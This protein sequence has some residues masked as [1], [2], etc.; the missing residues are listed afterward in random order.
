MPKLTQIQNAFSAG[1]ISPRLYGRTDIPKYAQAAKTMR[2]AYPLVHGGAR[3][4][5]GLRKNGSDIAFGGAE[6][7][8]VPFAVNSSE[9]YFVFV[10]GY[11]SGSASAVAVHDMRA[12]LSSLRF[13]KTGPWPTSE[14]ENVRWARFEDSIYFVHPSYPPYRL[15]RLSSD[16]SSANAFRFETVPFTHQPAE[17]IGEWPNASITL[18][19]TSGA[20]VNVTA[21]AA[22]FQTSDVGRYIESAAGRGLITT[23]TSTTQVTINTGTTTFEGLA[24]AA[25]LWR[26]SDS[27]QTTCTPSTT[28]PIGQTITLTLGAAGWK[29]LAALAHVGYSVEINGGLVQIT[30]FT[31]TTVVNAVVRTVL[32]SSSLAAPGGWVLKAPAW[33]FKPTTKSYPAAV[34]VYQ[35]RLVLA[36]TAF[37]P[38]T[39]WGS[40]TGDPLD[41]STG[42][43]DEDAFSFVISG[44]TAA[45]EHLVPVG[46]LLAF[47]SQGEI[48]IDGGIEKPITPTNVNIKPQSNY[49]CA[50]ARPIVVGSEVIFVQAGERKVRAMSYRG[51]SDS[52]VSDDLTVLSEHITEGL[53]RDICY[54][55]DPDSLIW[56]VLRD[57]T[58][59]SCTYDRANEVMGWAR[60]DTDGHVQCCASLQFSGRSLTA[61]CVQRTN[62]SGA[63]VPQSVELFDEN[64]SVD[65]AQYSTTWINPD[66]SNQNLVI[67]H[68]YVS[69]PVPSGHAVA[70]RSVAGSPLV[71]PGSA[72]RYFEVTIEVDLPGLV[73]V[74]IYDYLSFA[75]WEIDDNYIGKT[76]LAAWG[77][78]S[79]GTRRSSAG[80][81]AY[82]AAFGEGDVIGVAYDSST[83]DVTFYKNNV[84]LGV[85][86]AGTAAPTL[87]SVVI[88]FDRHL[89]FF[90]YEGS[91]VRVNL[92]ESTFTYTP[93]ASHAAWASSKTTWGSLPWATNAVTGEGKYL[94]TLP[95]AGL[96]TTPLAVREVWQGAPY[97]TEIV[98]LPPEIGTGT[99]SSQGNASSAHE[100]ILRIYRSAGGTFDGEALPNTPVVGEV[101]ATYTGDYRK[102]ALGW[103][104]TGAGD[105]DGSLAITHDYPFDFQ[106][107]ALIRRMTAN[108]G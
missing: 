11:D 84:S 38:T 29:N 52:F 26:I 85:A 30:A 28:G 90:G 94:G 23:F 54:A 31:S 44:A 62:Y 97:T 56:C 74:G 88:S 89:D 99:G 107:L 91:K 3:R 78:C 34:A 19:A 92:G 83:G 96:L 87:R 18:A 33:T 80:S 69:R 77:Y 4:R 1:E 106:I 93:P 40:V 6:T 86:F 58:F 24:I 63:L 25:E 100:L 51:D 41:F 76:G 59:I 35:Q 95:G 61:L 102:T 45:V 15:T 37:F 79:D 39:L 70:W 66:Y 10:S 72:S 7:L 27:P 50:R 98:A 82:A 108:D 36:S 81:A 32:A 104:R 55:Q 16:R 101:P 12:Q 49:G 48:R 65:G 14:L 64:V 9:A 43:G 75:N 68:P 22:C 105:W 21:S 2:N 42:A 8:A 57:G 13:T 17:E 20:A 46:S 47:T 60:H 5:Q 73:T 53:V 71:F 103:G 67:T